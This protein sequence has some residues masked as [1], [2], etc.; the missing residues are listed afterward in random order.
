MLSRLNQRVS[1]FCKSVQEGN[2]PLGDSV[3]PLE[4]GGTGR[5]GVSRRA[6]R[7]DHVHAVPS[8]P[9]LSA[10]ASLTD[11]FLFEDFILTS[12][13]APYVSRYG[14]TFASIADARGVLAVNKAR[15]GYGI[16]RH[17]TAGAVNSGVGSSFENNGSTAADTTNQQNVISRF[18][19][20][21]GRA[22]I[23]LNLATENRF[24]V[25]GFIRTS[26]HA[27]LDLITDG[28]YVLGRTS[29]QTGTP[30]TR[31]IAWS[32]RVSRNS[33]TFAKNIETPPPMGTLGGTLAGTEFV[34]VEIELDDEEDFD[35]NL[36][37]SRAFFFIND[38]LAATI[39][40]SAHPNEFPTDDDK[41]AAVG[42]FA[43]NVL[44]SAG[45]MDLD[46]LLL[47]SKK[48]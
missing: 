23:V 19:K 20:F 47:S 2:I 28:I 10:E 24:F 35:G 18:K 46:Y 31:G 40:A 17:T 44:S 15:A 26:T 1:Q 36:R 12:N 32:A 29:G 21:A 9:D 4:F 22:R 16:F 42:V 8:L 48:D 37:P 7:E 39:E 27:R 3:R 38:E 34:K 30:D 13:Q 41:I 43:M 25:F 6:S 5:G 45:Q 11:P 14:S 33:S